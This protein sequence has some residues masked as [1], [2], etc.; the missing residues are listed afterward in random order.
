MLTIL[1]IKMT[2]RIKKKLPS[3]F[4]GCLLL[5]ICQSCYQSQEGCLDVLATNFD[6]TADIDCCLEDNVCCC[7]YPTLNLAIDH[8][9]TADTSLNFALG[10]PLTVDDSSHFFIVDD[11]KFYLTNL[12]LVNT[13]T[14]EEAGVEDSI[15]LY[16]IDDLGN[17]VTTTVEDN[18]SLINRNQFSYPLGEF[19]SSGIYDALRFDVGIAGLANHTLTDSLATNH[20]L[21]IQTDTLQIDPVSG[22][23]FNKIDLR[24]D[25]VSS[26][27]TNRIEI[28][29]LIA[30]QLA[31][32]EP[33]TIANGFD[34]TIN[35]RMNHLDWY[36]GINFVTDT[37]EQIVNKIVLNT[38]NVF[39]IV[40]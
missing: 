21:S 24:R 16:V 18:F 22:Y 25:T 39:K 26:T 35:L 11:I 3:F 23:I 9:L 32:N 8:K 14:G 29:D 1:E 30:V 20:A 7:T 27:A 13:T 10:S 38:T 12:H 37:D 40:E 15:E 4:W 17:L 34:I 31:L 5:L 36:T 19:R 28:L 33:I 2:I 6:V